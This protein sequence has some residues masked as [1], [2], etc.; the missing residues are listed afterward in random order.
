MRANQAGL[1]DHGAH[2]TYYLHHARCVFRLTNDPLLG[3]LEFYFEGTVFTDETDQKTVRRDLRAEL[4]R[5]TCDWL[6]E[7]VVAWFGKTV[8]HAVRAEF[9]RYIAAGDLEV[10]VRRIETICAASDESGGFLGMYL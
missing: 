7:P 10:A 1:A 6:T 5:E 8:S 4:I 3:M 2:N 9:D